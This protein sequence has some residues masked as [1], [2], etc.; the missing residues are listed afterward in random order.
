MKKKERKYFY[1]CPNCGCGTCQLRNSR[2]LDSRIKSQ[3]IMERKTIRE[4]EKHDVRTM[5]VR[6]KHFEGVKFRHGF[7]K[8]AFDTPAA[9]NLTVRCL[10]ALY[11]SGVNTIEDV[12]N[13]S[14]WKLLKRTKNFG[15][16][17]FRELLEFIHGGTLS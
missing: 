15:P 5:T 17:S 8:I 10:N 6:E 2:I 11:Q 14:A 13:M 4:K 9:R 3:E 7:L 16:T 1:Y 12:L